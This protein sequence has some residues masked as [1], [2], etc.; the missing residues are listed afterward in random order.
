LNAFDYRSDPQGLRCPLG[1]HIRRA[2]PRNADLPTGRNGFLSW[3]VRTLGFNG[4]A[5][6]QDLVASTRFHRLLRRGREYGTGVTPAQALAGIGAG[7]DRGLHFLCLNANL[8]RQFEFVQSAWLMSSK[9]DGMRDESDP[10]LGNRLQLAAGMPADCFSVAQPNGPSQRLTGLPQ[11]VT[12]LG[13]AYFFLP[14][15]RALRFL[16]TTP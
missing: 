16:S 2:N 15:I 4:Q 6:E 5:R 10:L 13:G 9:F 1:A 7:E 11:F 14:G 3:L 8:Q 12:V